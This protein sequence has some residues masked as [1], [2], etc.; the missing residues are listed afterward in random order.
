MDFK[1]LDKVFSEYIRRRDADEYGRVKC[2]TCDTVSHWA[3]MDC[4]HWLMRSKMGTRFDERNCH[5][6]CR[7]CNRHLDGE[8]VKHHDYIKAR[9]DGEET[10]SEL[11]IE[12]LGLRKWM[13]YEIDEMVKEYKLKLK[14][15]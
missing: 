10:I 2:C 1:K 9:Y 15:L 5:A 13:Q 8:W 11:G 14:S 12:S 3:E 4:G 6:Q 7:I